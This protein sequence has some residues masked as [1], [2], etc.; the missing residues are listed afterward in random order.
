V[1]AAPPERPAGDRAVVVAIIEALNARD[2]EAVG[3]L[4]APQAEFRSYLA[5]VEGR[6]YVGLDGVRQYFADL[7][8]T[9]DEVRW[10]ALEIEE[11]TEGRLAVTVDFLARGRGSG[12]EFERRLTNVFTIVDGR[13]ACNEVFTDPAEARRAAGLDG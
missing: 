8:D 9:F 1:T 4:L 2:A 6:T 11:G 13:V 7:A 12:L 5:S 3:E 10:S